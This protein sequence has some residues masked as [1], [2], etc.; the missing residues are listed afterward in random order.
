MAIFFQ[1]RRPTSAYH[2]RRADPMYTVRVLQAI[3]P[4]SFHKT[5]IIFGDFIKIGADKADRVY[6]ELSNVP[7]VKQALG[8]VSTL[9][10]LLLS[11]TVSVTKVCCVVA[12][13]SAVCVGVH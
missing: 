10:R 12:F 9:R 1:A 11:A 6:E 2:D 4:A 13:V 3:E 8:D 5:P 7:K